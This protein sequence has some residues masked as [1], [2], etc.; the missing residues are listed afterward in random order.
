MALLEDREAGAGAREG[1]APSSSAAA[2]V[3]APN[4]A[5]ST[6]PHSPRKAAAEGLGARSGAA[7]GPAGGREG[8]AAA[9]RGAGTAA[10][11]G[12]TAAAAGTTA[13]PAGA[14]EDPHVLH[15]ARMARR[16]RD[17]A[18]CASK[19]R[20]LAYLRR[21]EAGGEYFADEAMRARDPA[22]YHQYVGRYENPRGESKIEERGEGWE[23]GAE[24]KKERRGGADWTDLRTADARYSLTLWR[25]G[26]VVKSFVFMSYLA[27]PPPHPPTSREQVP[28]GPPPWAPGCACR[29]PCWCRAMSWT[30]SCD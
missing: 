22:L 21:L 4:G 13:D 19:N 23:V 1:G 16:A 11:A 17:R 28:C 6:A 8:T 24:G 2:A 5:P 7:A 9:G 18:A 29:R 20:R 12:A 27:F 25:K 15:A 30:C 14:A 26:L 3:P 10:G